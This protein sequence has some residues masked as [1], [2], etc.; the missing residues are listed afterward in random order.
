[1]PWDTGLLPEQRK[2]A[3]HIGAHACLRAGP[4]TGK[5]LTLSRRVVYLIVKQDISPNEILALTFTRAAVHEL[6]QKIQKELEPYGKVLP[7]VS[8]LHSFALRQLIRNFDKITTVPKPLRIADDWEERNI[9]LEDLKDMLN[10]NLRRT[11]EKFNRLSADWQ[12]LK[13]DEQNWEKEYQD[14]EF[15]GTWR[16]HSQIYGY[17]LRLQLVYELKKALEHNPDFSLE[18]S[19]K[20]LLVDEYQDLNPCD[21]AMIGQLVKQGVELFATGDDDQSIYGFRFAEPEGIRRFKKDYSPSSLLELEFCK[22]C[23]KRIIDVG[24]F[25][26]RLDPRRIKKRL[27]PMPDAEDGEVQV[28]WFNNQGEEAEVIAQICKNLTQD[29]NYNP[30]DILILIRTDHNGVFSET[31]R[32]SLEKQGIPVAPKTDYAAPLDCIEGR[33]LLGYL[34]L[35]INPN[36]HLAWRTLLNVRRN[37]IGTET[38]SAVY[39]QALRKGTTFTAALEEIRNAPSQLP[40]LGNKLSIELKAISKLVGKFSNKISEGGELMNNIRQLAEHVISDEEK[41]EEIL[42]CLQE[43]LETSDEQNLANLLSAISASMEDK[44]QDI[45]HEKVN[46]LTTHKAKGLTAD[47]VFLVGAEDEYIPG[48]QLGEEAQGDERRLLYVSLTR[49]RHKLFITHCKKRTGQ[50]RYTGRTS[51]KFKRTLSRFL[52]DTPVITQSGVEY[53]NS[54]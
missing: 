41:R 33:E 12:R 3:R 13:A 50:Q 44:E 21:L 23:D 24:Q 19:Y 26:V 14:P 15:I 29:Q 1:M 49:A 39:D 51:G 11:H 9:I 10:I 38:I 22:R 18:Q 8:T 31:L 30:Q 34:R 5:T 25:V 36:D 46:I 7:R 27:R 16:E 32:Q 48:N 52:A 28:L 6:R 54:L 47:V 37:F 20:H 42:V 40:R 53:L 17:T 45:D 2:A 43:I 35:L 4:G